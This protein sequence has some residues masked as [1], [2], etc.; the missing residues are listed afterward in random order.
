M[1]RVRLLAAA[2]LTLTVTGQAISSL[3]V[4][5]ASTNPPTVIQAAGGSFPFGKDRLQSAH[6]QWTADWLAW[7]RTHDAEF[8]LKAAVVEQEIATSGTSGVLRARLETVLASMSD[9]LL[10]TDSD[11]CVTSVNPSAS[12]LTG[13]NAADAVGRAAGLSRA[14]SPS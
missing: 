2:A 9:G 5:A 6:A 14:L 4:R 1:I 8:K 13:V 3:P 7:E 11:G 10:A 12:A